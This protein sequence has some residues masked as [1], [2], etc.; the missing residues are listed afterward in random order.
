M[1]NI[2]T[3]RYFSDSASTSLASSWGVHGQG[4]VVG[5][6]QRAPLRFGRCEVRVGS[7]EVWVD[8]QLR[9]LQPRPFDLLVCLIDSRDR[10]RTTDEL[11][12]EIW[13]HE[14]VQPGSLAAAVMRIRQALCEG[15]PGIGQV[16][17]TYPRVGYRFVAQLEGDT[18]R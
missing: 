12:D 9:A 13:R 14:I 11:L 6:A 10:V 5:L 3:P 4:P 16:I 7:R 8:G 2:S 18:P 17:R 1:F 15:E